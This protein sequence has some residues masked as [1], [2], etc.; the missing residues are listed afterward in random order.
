[1]CF[2]VCN[3]LGWCKRG[4]AF[5]PFLFRLLTKTVC[6]TEHHSLVMIVGLGGPEGGGMRRTLSQERWFKHCKSPGTKVSLFLKANGV[7]PVPTHTYSTPTK[8]LFAP[9]LLRLLT[10]TVCCVWRQAEQ[11][12][13]RCAPRIRC[14]AE[15]AQWRCRGTAHWI[16]L[17]ARG[18]EVA[19]ASGA[20]RCENAVG[21]DAETA[22]V[23]SLSMRV[24]FVCTNPGNLCH[25][26][27][28]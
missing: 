8:K 23:F 21:N 7:L 20:N 19:S 5:G 4:F 3:L 2:F 25:R 1:M 11:Q 28:Q 24:N 12:S 22:V 16:R 15:V 18:Y 27:V 26:Q 6:S 9:F 14:R 17:P 10:K 13:T